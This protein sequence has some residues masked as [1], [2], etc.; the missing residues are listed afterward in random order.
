MQHLE[1][2][3][4]R[5]I[6]HDEVEVV[7][8]LERVVQRDDE[9]MVGRGQDLSFRESPLD[10]LGSGGHKQRSAEEQMHHKHRDSIDYAPCSW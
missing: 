9:G 2:L 1:E 5:T 8:R 4:A 10:L 3:A 7:L 6:V